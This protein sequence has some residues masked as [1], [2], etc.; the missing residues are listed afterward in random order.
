MINKVKKALLFFI[1]FIISMLPFFIKRIL[2]VKI[3]GA[4]IHPA[5]RIGFLAFIDAKKIVIGQKSQVR[6]FSVIR[7]V[8]LFQMGINSNFSSF[9]YVTAIPKGS[10]KHFVNEGNR[11]PALIIGDHSGIGKSNFFDCCNTIKIGSY[12]AVAGIRTAMF[13][14]GINIK[15]CIQETAPINIGNYARIGTCSVVLKG[16]QLPS[17]STLGANSTLQKFY[18]QEYTLYS[19][20]PA[21]PVKHFDPESKYFKRTKGFVD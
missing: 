8:E 16:S 13:T 20:V 7:N 5:A 15:D 17:Y 6:S 3:W 12:S 9:N 2:Y 18:E 11:F 10:K 1:L 19:G 21:I 14:H 4:E